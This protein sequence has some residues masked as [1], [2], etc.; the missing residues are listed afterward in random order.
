M[1]VCKAT[2][3]TI[4]TTCATHFPTPIDEVMEALGRLAVLR[5]HYFDEKGAR[6]A[7]VEWRRDSGS[8]CGGNSC[9]PAGIHP[10][11]ARFWD[12]LVGGGQQCL[13]RSARIRELHTQLGCT[14]LSYQAYIAWMMWAAYRRDIG[15][16]YATGMEFLYEL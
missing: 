14:R 10:P 2:E 9:F 11:D 4:D 16:W 1:N 3:V 8:N 12:T 13:R 5:G 7:P 15:A 6:S